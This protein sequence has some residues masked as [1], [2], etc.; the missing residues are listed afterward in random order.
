MIETLRVRNFKALRDIE[1]PLRP[2]TVLIGP[3][4]SGKSS[5]LEALH[6]LGRCD[7]GRASNVRDDHAGRWDMD[8][9]LALPLLLGPEPGRMV[10]RG[11]PER[12]IELD[13]RGESPGSEPFHY[14]IQFGG[15]GIKGWVEDEEATFNK[16]KLICQNPD[17]TAF[18]VPG[19][20]PGPEFFDKP[21]GSIPILTDGQLR[22]NSLLAPLIAALSSQMVCFRPEI[23]AMPCDLGAAKQGLSP[24]GY[25]LAA[26]IDALLTGPDR[27]AI[28][29]LEEQ[30]HRVVPTIRGVSLV[31]AELP[32]SNGPRT[33]KALEFVL[34]GSPGQPV[35]TIPATQAS[36]GAILAAGYLALVY[37]NTAG[38]LLI[39]EPENGLHPTALGFI[40]ELLQKISRGEIG[41]APRQVILTT[42]SPLLLNFVDP[43]DVLIV[44]RTEDN[45]RITPMVDTPHF[46]EHFTDFDL[47]ELWYNLGEESLVKEQ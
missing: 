12:I 25:G 3:N 41:P 21:I 23:L 7:Q 39:E 45:V 13:A 32:A 2:F 15:H 18:R 17:V 28:Q 20:E 37:S 14:R 43:E 22:A 46:A 42:H 27:S 9:L 34:D 16:E 1:V 36:Q 6:V 33:G 8:T 30:L 10:Y 29:H 5:I 38:R 26:V 4:D 40:V 11:D 44:T 24:Q 35:V 19:D 47:G 31:T